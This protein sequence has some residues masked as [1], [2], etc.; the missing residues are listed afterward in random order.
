MPLS[1]R[2]GAASS[3]PEVRERLVLDSAHPP[4]EGWFGTDFP[5]GVDELHFLVSGVIKDIA[6]LKSLF[7]LFAVTLDQ[8]CRMGSAYKRDP[9]VHLK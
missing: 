9:G 2:R 1:E 3:P 7:D 5:D 6:H 4:D 8:L